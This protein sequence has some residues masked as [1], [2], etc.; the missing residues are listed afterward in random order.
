MTDHVA[1]P[2]PVFNALLE[3]LSTSLNWTQVNPLMVALQKCEK[4]EAIEPES[5]NGPT[6][7][8]MPDRTVRSGIDSPARES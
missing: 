6:T 1:V 7:P 4:I 3:T 8:N 5:T 2:M